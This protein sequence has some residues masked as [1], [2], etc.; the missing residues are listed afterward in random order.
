[1]GAGNTTMFEAAVLVIMLSFA[2]SAISMTVTK[3]VVFKPAREWIVDKSSW[4]GKLFTCP[5][6]FSH[7]V[8][9][10]VVFIWKPELLDSGLWVL[11]MLM[12]AM[13]MVAIAA[14]VSFLIFTSIAAIVTPEE[15]DDDE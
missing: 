9:F 13:I 6:C 1:V 7:W 4:F 10:V 8:A 15:Y 5:Y 2:V 11:D 14:P 3:A 12:T